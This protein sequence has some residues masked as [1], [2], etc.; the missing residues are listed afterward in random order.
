MPGYR[1]AHSKMWST[2]QWFGEL[3]PAHKLLF[4]YLF[5]NER[6]SVSGLY[7]LPLRVIQFETG[8]DAEQIR[9]GLETFASADKVHYD[10]SASVVWVRN[11]WKYQGSKSPKVLDRARKDMDAVPACP[12][13]D[14]CLY[15]NTIS[16]LYGYGIEE[17]G[18]GIDTS[19]Y[20]SSSSYI[21]SSSSGE[22][23][24]MGEETK[25][26]PETPKQAMAHPDIQVYERVTKGIPGMRDY[27]TVI[28]TIQSLREK[29]GSNLDE[30]L[31]PYWTAWSTRKTKEGKP[32]SPTS[33]VWLC[34]WAVR[35]EIPRANGHE[36]KMDQSTSDVIR[37]VAG[38]AKRR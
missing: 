7:E 30:Y 13:K 35:G 9:S 12:L 5:T 21:Y 24:G 26:Y 6:A 36:P 3:S 33:M 2:D 1:Q 23:G 8:L 29:H 18:D 19:S 16:I 22:G 27:R 32:Y 10:W 11:M 28:D 15:E 25:G 20:S 4:I 14:K 37:K 31:I 34:E 38:N 17:D